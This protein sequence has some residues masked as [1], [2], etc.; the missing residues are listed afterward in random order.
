MLPTPVIPIWVGAPRPL[1]PSV[2]ATP[3]SHAAISPA[4]LAHSELRSGSEQ[5]Q[6]PFL[7]DRLGREPVC[8]LAA[9][10]IALCVE[11]VE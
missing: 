10:S 4:E 2:V 6:S 7:S 8:G 1:C 9:G 11:L 5:A 3:A